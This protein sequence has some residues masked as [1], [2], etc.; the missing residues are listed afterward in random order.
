VDFV[1][2]LAGPS[3]AGSVDVWTEETPAR[4]GTDGREVTVRVPAR[5]VAA[6]FIKN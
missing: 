6:V 1:F 4:L 2:N 5:R 3:P